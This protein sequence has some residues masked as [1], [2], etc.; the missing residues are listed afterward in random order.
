MHLAAD[1]S[2][3]GSWNPQIG[4]DAANPRTRIQGQATRKTRVILTY[5]NKKPT[6]FSGRVSQGLAVDNVYRAKAPKETSC[7]RLISSSL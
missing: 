3:R 4:L 5:P 7:I 1:K 6:R 2:A